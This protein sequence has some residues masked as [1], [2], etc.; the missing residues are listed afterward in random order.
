MKVGHEHYGLFSKKN[1]SN[2]YFLR[3]G[4]GVETV[5][6]NIANVF[7]NS[8][9]VWKEWKRFQEVQCHLCTQNRASQSTCYYERRWRARGKGREGLNNKLDFGWVW[10]R[11][12][13]DNHPIWHDVPCKEL[14]STCF[15]VP[16]SSWETSSFRFMS[17]VGRAARLR[18]RRQEYWERYRDREEKGNVVTYE[19]V[20]ALVLRIRDDVRLTETPW[21]L[22][23]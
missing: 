16:P 20:V 22:M 11:S 10:C 7:T 18:E 15:P 2:Y 14:P 21:E 4:E 6:T 5:E 1:A 12:P 3:K 9:T 19:I 17:K 13:V 8:R 23:A